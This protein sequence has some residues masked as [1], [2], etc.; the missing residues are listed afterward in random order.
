MTG[1]SS[2]SARKPGD[3]RRYGKKQV[4]RRAEQI[5]AEGMAAMQ[6]QAA[7]NGEVAADKGVDPLPPARD[8][9]ACG[10]AHDR[11]RKI[12]LFCRDRHHSG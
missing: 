10:V 9:T 7:G 1:T 6:C 4:E 5:P 3:E 2:P 12:L 11:S 8:V